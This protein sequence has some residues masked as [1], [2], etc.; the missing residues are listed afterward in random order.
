V[1]AIAFSIPPKWEFR[2]EDEAHMLVGIYFQGKKVGEY[3]I[4]RKP[5]Y[6]E[7]VKRSVEKRFKE[8]DA[9]KPYEYGVGWVNVWDWYWNVKNS[10]EDGVNR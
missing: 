2:W 5:T 1:E 7:Q 4:E 6:A 3:S 8:Y 10:L 9:I